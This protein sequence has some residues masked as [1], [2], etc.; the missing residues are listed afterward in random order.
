MSLS[1]WSSLNH[2]SPIRLVWFSV[3]SLNKLHSVKNV[4]SASEPKVSALEIVAFVSI[5]DIL[6]YDA[7]HWENYNL[8]W[9]IFCSL[10]TALISI[11]PHNLNH[12]NSC[13]QFQKNL[14]LL[15]KQFIIK[16]E[17]FW[18]LFNII[19]NGCLLLMV[20]LIEMQIIHLQK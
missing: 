13:Y 4:A 15:T 16:F 10:I 11:L 14:I 2:D 6:F 9:I 8:V 3:I 7:I 20:L 19:K 17:I 18:K 1:S 5:G 12:L